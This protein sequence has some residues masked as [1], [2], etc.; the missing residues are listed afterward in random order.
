MRYILTNLLYRII[1]KKQQKYGQPC[2]LRCPNY[3]KFNFKQATKGRPY[4]NGQL[5]L[6]SATKALCTFRG[7]S[8]VITLGKCFGG[9]RAKVRFLKQALAVSRRGHCCS[10]CHLSLRPQTE[11]AGKYHIIRASLNAAVSRRK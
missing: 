4:F 9:S 2:E 11:D 10:F 5:Q 8:S 3:Q 7:V 1:N 6:L